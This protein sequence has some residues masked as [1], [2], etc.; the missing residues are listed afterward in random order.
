MAADWRRNVCSSILLI[1][2]FV[3]SCL[4]V[5]LAVML[6]MPVQDCRKEGCLTEF[7]L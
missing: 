7:P 4:E 5:Y 3:R 2:I 1:I 6:V